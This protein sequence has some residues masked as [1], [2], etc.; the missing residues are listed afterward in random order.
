MRKILS[1]AIGVFAVFAAV[2]PPGAPAS[3]GSSGPLA[4]VVLII[5]SDCG[6]RITQS[7]FLYSHN[8]ETVV[9][10]ALHGVRGCF[11]QKSWSGTANVISSRGSEILAPYLVDV[12]HD[13]I[14]YKYVNPSGI[15]ALQKADKRPQSGDTIKVA[16]FPGRVYRSIMRSVQVLDPSHATLDS[17]G[18]VKDFTAHG[19]PTGTL[20]MLMLGPGPVP[21]DSG[22]PALDQQDKVVG[23]I[24]GGFLHPWSFATWA[25]PVGSLNLTK[26]DTPENIGRLRTLSKQSS[27]NGFSGSS[28]ADISLSTGLPC[29]RTDADCW[30]EIKRTM[31]NHR[32]DYEMGAT[33][34]KDPGRCSQSDSPKCAYAFRLL[35]QMPALC[36]AVEFDIDHFSDVDYCA[37]NKYATTPDCD[38]HLSD[39]ASKLYDLMDRCA[40]VEKM[41]SYVLKQAERVSSG[42][43]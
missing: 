43:P 10:T 33:M 39:D 16:G 42:S 20:E 28:L 4:S 1:I 35:T 21:G 2:P 41:E 18:N 31:S 9:I 25:V 23:V 40:N 22:G 37:A 8:G 26:W 32:A 15:A 5:P 13:V 19:S 6:T 36:A 7:G 11:G 38:A 34:L 30:R 29:P 17:F 14:A 24:N 27:V 12:E 3:P